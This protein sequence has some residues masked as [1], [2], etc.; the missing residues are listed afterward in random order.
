MAK[1]DANARLIRLILLLQKFDLKIKDNK[2]V[3][4]VVADHLS[5]IPNPPVETTPINEDFS[6]E[7][8]LTMC[9]ELWYMIVH[10]FCI[11][12]NTLLYLSCNKSAN[13]LVLNVYFAEDNHKEKED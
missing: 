11:L 2:G 4:N 6:N 12:I 1:K 9:H 8:I 5:C 3:E 10:I 7:H 13:F